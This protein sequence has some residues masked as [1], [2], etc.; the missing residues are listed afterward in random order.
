MN[1]QQI[2][3]NMEMAPLTMNT[4]FNHHISIP[5]PRNMEGITKELAHHLQPAIPAAPSKFAKIPAE[6]SPLKPLATATPL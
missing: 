1:V 2:A 4:L 3:K 5:R 6:T